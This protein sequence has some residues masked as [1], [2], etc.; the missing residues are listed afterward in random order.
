[1]TAARP[2]EQFLAMND[3]AIDL[4]KVDEVTLALMHLTTFEERGVIRTWKGHAWEV[5]NRLHERGWIS[6]PV[7]KS[8]SVKLSDE[9]ARKSRELFERHFRKAE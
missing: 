3:Q 6:N 7:L 8:K 4:D 2:S 9:A 5:L 1:L